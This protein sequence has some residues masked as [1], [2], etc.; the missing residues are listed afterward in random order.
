M[1]PNALLHRVA[2]LDA[3]GI[4]VGKPRALLAS[5]LCKERI[6]NLNVTL[7]EIEVLTLFVF[8]IGKTADFYRT[9]FAAPV[10]YQDDVSCVMKFGGLMINLLDRTQ[11]PKL[12]E[13]RQIA[14]IA[15]GPSAL[16]TVKVKDVDAACEQLRAKG[17]VLLNGPINRP[18]G[19]R[20]ASFEDPAGN[21]WEVAQEL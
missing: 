6:P 19:R 16:L 7:N 5:I 12:V 4:A 18:W 13:P 9:V 21:V 10:V 1:T 17:V 20:T 11:A 15:A 2:G 3:F 14:G 8:D